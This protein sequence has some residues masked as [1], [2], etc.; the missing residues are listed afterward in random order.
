MCSSSVK[1]VIGSLIR[2]VLN[3]QIALGSIR[4][5]TILILPICE[6]GIL[7][8][9][10]VSSFISFTSVLQFSI[11]RSFVSLGKFIPKYFILFV[12]VVNGIVSLISLSDFSLLLYTNARDFCVLILYPTALLYSLIV[13]FQWHLEGFLWNHVISRWILD[14]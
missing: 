1:N 3:L 11:Y 6:R 12:A 10:F 14:Q 5:F 7:L 4:I 13:I 9:L 2:F 8:Y